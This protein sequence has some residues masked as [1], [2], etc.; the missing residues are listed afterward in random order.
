MS[1]NDIGK[2]GERIAREIL[3]KGL[4][5]DGIFQADWIVRKNGVYYVV[6]VKHKEIYK[7]PPF[8]GHGLDIR[9]VRAR[10]QFMQDTGIRCLFLVI[11][12]NGTVYWQWLD[13]LENGWHFDTKN[14]VRVYEIGAFKKL[15]RW[16]DKGVQHGQTQ[17]IQR[18]PEL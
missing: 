9:Q 18:S 8:Y 6:E 12:M 13:V 5:V 1:I 3:K 4:R 11:D 16:N 10:M 17:R 14:N 7:P 2:D 15:G